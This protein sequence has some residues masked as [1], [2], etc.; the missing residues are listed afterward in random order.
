VPEEQTPEGAKA[1]ITGLRQQWM[2][3]IRK[4]LLE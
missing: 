1:Y 4:I 3:Y 2:P